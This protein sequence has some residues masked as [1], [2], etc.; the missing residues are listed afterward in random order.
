MVQWR[1]PTAAGVLR[2]CQ[3]P[4]RLKK[5]SDPST[6]DTPSKVLSTRQQA[7][8]SASLYC[9]EPE[10]DSRRLLKNLESKGDLFNY[11][12]GTSEEKNIFFSG[13]I[14]DIFKSFTGFIGIDAL[15]LATSQLH[16]RNHLEHATKAQAHLSNSDSICFKDS[17]GTGLA[18]F[19]IEFFLLKVD[20]AAKKLTCHSVVASRA[21]GS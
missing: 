9:S 8:P 6:W 12:N 20:K 7:T 5:E 18:V 13:R 16:G 14:N 15:T 2:C 17:N 21:L 4:R 19:Q 1:E 3:I 10:E 11:T